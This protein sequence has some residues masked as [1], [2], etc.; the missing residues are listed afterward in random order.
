MDWNALEADQITCGVLIIW[1]KRALEKMEA[2]VGTFLVSVKWQGVVDGFIWAC[3]GV[4]G[5][6]DNNERRH[7]WDE[8]VGIQQY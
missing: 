1:D 7:M 6:N 5:P 8:L 2:M 3:S 4:Y